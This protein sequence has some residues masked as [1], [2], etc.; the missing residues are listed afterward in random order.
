MSRSNTLL[1]LILTAVH[2]HILGFCALVLLNTALAFL[3]PLN[4]YYIKVVTDQIVVASATGIDILSYLQAS[5][6][7][8]VGIQ[9]L[10]QVVK[11]IFYWVRV[12]TLPPF[13]RSIS[14]KIFKTLLGH[15]YSYYSERQ[16]GNI[17]SKI[18][19]LPKNAERLVGIYFIDMYQ[20]LIVIGFTLFTTW[21]V[22]VEFT[23]GAFIWFI[24]HI[25]IALLFIKPLTTRSEY[26]S[27]TLSELQG[28]MAD[29][30]GQISTVQLFAGERSEMAYVKN[31]LNREMQEFKKL[32]YHIESVNILYS[33][34][35]TLFI[36]GTIIWTIHAHTKNLIS[37]GDVILLITFSMRLSYDVQRLVNILNAFYEDLGSAK[38]AFDLFFDINE[39]KA[40]DQAP[41]L[42]VKKGEIHIKNL[43]F[44][45]KDRKIFEDLNLYIRPREHIGI[46]GPSGSGKSTLARLIFR[47]FDVNEGK[48]LIDGQDISGVTLKSLRE[49]VSCVPQSIELFH[50]SIAEN[51][52]Y[53][54]SNATDEEMIN[55]AKKAMCHDFISALPQGYATI[56]GEKGA[57][58][59]GG[60][61][62]RIAIA[63]AF[64]KKSPIFIM[65]EATSAL[66]SFI[67]DQV[68]QNATE[69]L[70]GKTVVV[71]AHRLSSVAKLDRIIVLQNGKVIEQ[72]T[73]EFLLSL[74]GVYKQLWEAQSKVEKQEIGESS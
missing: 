31:F 32:I 63:R 27:S 29:S 13:K 74:N 44:S 6:Y 71:I 34:I 5:I 42:Q 47:Q 46:V 10:Y 56:A 52:K 65:D 26:Y 53:S 68:N 17:T 50:R 25:L 67:E 72:G 22:S 39:I 2:K 19:R 59:S 24:V 11:Y 20:L 66:D 7:Q 38:E 70:K 14:K 28:V 43:G 33:L 49:Q 30:I 73:H 61:R 4:T 23:C 9:V 1:N 62:Q 51:I 57:K 41:E 16:S 45:Y 54:I 64:L 3:I 69:L 36:V 15:S 48:I 58:L 60:Q 21:R 37:V 12:Q 35:S 8:W 55:A 18:N 40:L